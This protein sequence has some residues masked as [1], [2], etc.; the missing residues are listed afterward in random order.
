MSAIVALLNALDPEVPMDA[1]V[2]ADITA[3]R[4]KAIVVPIAFDT[5]CDRY[6]TP[7]NGHALITPCGATMRFLIR[8]V[9]PHDPRTEWGFVVEY[10]HALVKSDSPEPG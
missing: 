5:D 6:V 4:A 8:D 1:A 10:D 2:L 9:D 7:R 3:L